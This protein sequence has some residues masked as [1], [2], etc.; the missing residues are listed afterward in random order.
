MREK[1][2]NGQ[3][4]S[5]N[6]NKQARLTCERKVVSRYW[7]PD[8]LDVFWVTVYGA[9]NRLHDEPPQIQSSK[10]SH[11][12][13]STS[14]LLTT[15]H[16]HLSGLGRFGKATRI[17]TKLLCQLK[18]TFKNPVS[19]RTKASPWWHYTQALF[20][21]LIHYSY[22][23]EKLIHLYV[24]KVSEK[25]QQ[26]VEIYLLL[27][28]R[29]NRRTPCI[30]TL[31]QESLFVSLAKVHRNSRTAETEILFSRFRVLSSDYFPLVSFFQLLLSTLESK[32]IMQPAEWATV[33]AVPACCTYP[34]I[35]K[36]SKHT[37]CLLCSLEIPIELMPSVWKVGPCIRYLH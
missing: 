1:T 36:A 10:S 11:Y 24:F 34:R 25:F 19:G 29:S 28:D 14:V 15:I 32:H 18:T 20:T 27:D 7:K 17:S 8:F 3:I 13:T 6:G 33:P 23:W 2:R 30:F 22:Y 31:V 35:F 4:G 5:F 16:H 12:V 21:E 37:H 26:V 9:T